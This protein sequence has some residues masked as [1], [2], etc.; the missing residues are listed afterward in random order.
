MK[1]ICA[2][3]AALLIFVAGAVSAHAYDRKLETAVA[4]MGY[5]VMNKIESAAAD[6]ELRDFRM[7]SKQIYSVKSRKKVPGSDNLYYRFTIRIEDFASVEDAQKRAEHIQSTPPGPDS[8]MIGPEFALREGFQRG[9]RVYV[10]ST[11]VYTFVADK[12]LTEFHKRLRAA[13]TRNDK[14]VDI[15]KKCISVQD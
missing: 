4:A 12:S 9:S 6:W 14:C 15:S 7:R 1:M 8:K 3:F 11:D 5:R 10:I 2:G 13:V